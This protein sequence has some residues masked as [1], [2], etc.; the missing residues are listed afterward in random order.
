MNGTGLCTSDLDAQQCLP[1]IDRCSV[2][3]SSYGLEDNGYGDANNV[4]LRYA[5]QSHTI[6][7]DNGTARGI[8]VVV[9]DNNQCTITVRHLTDS[10]QCTIALRNLNDSNQCTIAVRNLTDSNQCT[11][12]VRNLTDSNQCTNV[13]RK[14]TEN[15][16]AKN[17]ENSL[18]KIIYFL[19][20]YYQDYSILISDIFILNIQYLICTLSFIPHF[21]MM[22]KMF[23]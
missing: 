16:N 14:F 13:V 8:T 17:T 1:I 6:F 22:S 19:R 23:L 2:E 7:N 12:T 18:L 3:V 21:R 20:M 5:E 11:I 15:P 4:Y 10:N 9:F